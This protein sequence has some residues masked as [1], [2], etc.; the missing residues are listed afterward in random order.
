MR[1]NWPGE[2]IANGNEKKRINQ[3]SSIMDPAI[4]KD[5]NPNMIVAMRYTCNRSSSSYG[6]LSAV[7]SLWAQYLNTRVRPDNDKEKYCSKSR[8][9]VRVLD[10]RVVIFDPA[11]TSTAHSKGVPDHFRR[12]RDQRYIFDRVFD[13]YSSQA[14]VYEHTAKVPP[15]RA[16][17][18]RSFVRRGI[19]IGG[20]G[21]GWREVG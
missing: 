18:V 7:R 5:P 2:E 16:S 8:T 9:V 21:W 11:D 4:E 14:E 6:V 15:S 12:S 1:E 10:E 17:F 13:Q 20:R 3:Q 19:D